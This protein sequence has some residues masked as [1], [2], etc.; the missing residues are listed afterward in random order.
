[1]ATVTTRPTAELPTVETVRAEIDAW[2]TENWSPDLTV[3]DWWGR[4]ATA[5]YTSPTLPVEAG[6]QGWGGDLAS[7][8]FAGLARA[9]VLGLPG[10]L[11]LL[12]AAPTIALHG[13]PEQVARY[14][15][16]ILDGTEGWCQLF[17]EPQAGSD[18][19]GLQ[20]RAERDGD[21]WVI[22]GQ[23]VWTSTAQVADLGM[24]LART[25]PDAPKH[26][27]ITYFLIDMRQPGIEIRPLKEMTGRAVFNEVFLD[28]ARVPHANILG[29]LNGGWKVANSTLGFERAGI[30]HGG[31][32]F[33]AA[34]PG[35]IAGHLDRRV[36]DF[37]NRKGAISGGAVGKRNINALFELAR[38]KGRADDPVVR[39][40]LAQVWTYYELTRMMGW[41][42]KALPRSRTGGEG[43]LAKI[44]NTRTVDAARDAANLLL[45]PEGQLWESPGAAGA[46][47][48][49]TVF[50]PA[51]PIY[52]G[53]DEIQRNVLGERVLG[54]PK[55]PGPP[56]DTPFRDLPK[57]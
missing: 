50:S 22:T 39:Q 46:F 27:G 33:A 17:S 55:E 14:V 47:Q 19:A 40:A 26:Q 51:P 43:N 49:M 20:T 1:L 44:H 11:G 7:A 48:E 41:K 2:I 18:L 29:E 35:S 25:N 54:L 32:S 28:G 5:R 12:L 42:A 56:A 16:G 21:E 31:T 57:N 4:L 13:T 3:R 38:A 6:G 36:G 45:G 34:N 24:L 23:K 30:G 52:G 8:V 9:R 15:P 37:L 53:S 10:G